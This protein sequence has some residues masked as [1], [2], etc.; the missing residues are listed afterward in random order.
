MT[1]DVRLASIN[2][3]DLFQNLLQLYM[4]DFTEFT[5]VDI[6]QTGLYNILPDFDSY[7]K[8]QN[9]SQPYLIKLLEDVLSLHLNQLIKVK[10]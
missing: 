9:D 8:E 6:N 3:K 1:I 2:E 4:Y 7:W 5:D 10:V